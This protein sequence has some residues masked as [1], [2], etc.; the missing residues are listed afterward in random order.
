M[1]DLNWMFRAGVCPV[2][3]FL[4]REANHIP[5]SSQL[6]HNAIPFSHNALRSRSLPANRNCPAIGPTAHSSSPHHDPR[7]GPEHGAAD[8]TTSRSRAAHHQQRPQLDAN[9]PLICSGSGSGHVRHLQLPKVL[10]K[11]G[12][13]H[14]VCAADVA[15]GS[16]DSGRRDLFRAE[17]S[18]DQWRNESASWAHQYLILGERH[19]GPGQDEVSKYPAGPYELRESTLSIQCS[20]A[21]FCLM[22]CNCTVPN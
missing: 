13:Q 17:D 16:G 15:E 8:G 22:A 2:W 1:V 21:L 6:A 18:M 14:T 3:R 9:I 12:Q 7:A 19:Q 20:E 11:R 4:P 10:F 5:T